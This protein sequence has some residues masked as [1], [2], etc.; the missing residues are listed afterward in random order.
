MHQPGGYADHTLH[1]L[2][3]HFPNAYVLTLRGNTDSSTSELLEEAFSTA[4]AAAA[5]EPLVV[6]LGGLS[7]GDEM[8]LGLLLNAQ[9]DGAVHLVGP[10]SPTFLRRLDVTGTLEL[11]TVHPSLSAALAEFPA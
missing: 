5:G 7:F 4:L 9:R 1:I 11:F 6:D 2:D 3:A 10:I 8:L